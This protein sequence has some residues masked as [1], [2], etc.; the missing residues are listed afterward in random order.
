[1]IRPAPTLTL[2]VPCFNEE[3]VLPELVAR[4]EP[5]L[6]GMVAAGD[7]RADSHIVFV[8]DGS[9]DRTWAEISALHARSP[10]FR[11]VKLSRNRGHQSA[12]MAGLAAAS[13]D[14]VISLDADLQDDPLAILR[15]VAAYR[16]GADVVYG[17]R[18]RRDS[19]TAFKRRSAHGYYWLLARLGVEIV[20]DHADYRLLS[21]RALAGL[22]EFREVNLFLRALVPQLGFQ[23]ATVTYERAE[24]FAGESKYPLR[25]MLN[26]AFEGITSFSTRP[27]RLIFLAGL[28]LSLI[29]FALGVWAIVMTVVF[30]VAVPGWASTVVPIYF[31]C[32]IQLL[33]LGV[34]GEYLGRLYLEAKARPRYL[35][36]ARLDPGADAPPPDAPALPSA[37][38]PARPRVTPPGPG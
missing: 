19:D 4:L 34:I 12:L 29:S 27:L 14:A 15:M 21:R 5:I 33:S 23:T 13:G 31:V 26:L 28:V 1:M 10:R 17:V 16:G 3:A 30:K 38:P 2:V 25:R 36:E 22:A 20:P 24:R 8:D 7:I 6:D 35:V 32:A 37:P 9:T 18:V 11:G